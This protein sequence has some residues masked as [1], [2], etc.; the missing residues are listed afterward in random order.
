MENESLLFIAPIVVFVINSLIIFLIWRLKNRKLWVIVNKNK[1]N[2]T[3]PLLINK[4]N[5]L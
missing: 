2:D 1:K 3:I 4:N 5:I